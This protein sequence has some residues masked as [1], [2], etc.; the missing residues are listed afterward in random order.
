MGAHSF[1]KAGRQCRTVLLFVVLGY[2]LASCGYYADLYNVDRMHEE[3]ILISQKWIGQSIDR[4]DENYGSGKIESRELPNGNIENAY[5]FSYGRCI[6]FYE[7][8]PET[9][10]IVNFRF[11]GLKR[12]CVQIP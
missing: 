10:I 12:W 9:R 3:F 5:G 7:F 1:L 6:E 8:D 11:E 2:M 4:F